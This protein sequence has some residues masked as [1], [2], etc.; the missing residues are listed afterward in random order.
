MAVIAFKQTAFELLFK[1]LNYPTQLRCADVKLPCRAIEV[2]CFGKLGE[3]SEFI[4]IHSVALS[5]IKYCKYIILHNVLVSL[6]SPRFSFT[7]NIG[8]AK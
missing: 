5:E 7:H 3:H 6:K 1:P 8:A 4:E 2:L